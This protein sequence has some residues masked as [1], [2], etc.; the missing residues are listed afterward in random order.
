MSRI[1]IWTFYIAIALLTSGCA[2]NGEGLDANGRPI[3]SG[4]GGGGGGG[5]NGPFAPTLQA[6][7]DNVF[8]PI[9]TTCHAGAAAPQGLRLDQNSAFAM[10]V[11]TPSA[12][13]SSLQR[14]TP[15]DPDSSYLI[16]KLEGRAAVGAQMPLGGPPLPQATINVIRQW[17]SNGAQA[18]ASAAPSAVMPM[19]LHSVLPAVA[20]A[21]LTPNSEVL[22][23]ADGELDASTLSAQ[24]LQLVRSGGDGSF[25]EG[26][27]S[28][29]LPIHLEVR[30]LNPTVLAIK[31]ENGA[32]APDSYRLTIAGHGP[33]PVTDIEGL[34][35]GDFSTEFTVG[36]AQ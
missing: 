12:E 3:G 25:S 29:V 31:L 4:G 26:N 32:W 18:T 9:C 16:Q 35:V 1:R 10:L 24:S 13:V 27:E 34:A 36:V 5:Q 2:G 17:I 22:V 33:A 23:Q 19:Q 7:Q 30:S 28:V 14:V 20:E 6:I 8:T 11:N 15:G 21:T